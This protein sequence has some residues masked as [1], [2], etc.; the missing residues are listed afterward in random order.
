MFDSGNAKKCG[1][2]SGL[3]I[4]TLD[5]QAGKRDR[6]HATQSI[7]H[8]DSSTVRQ[9]EK[10]YKILEKHIVY[11][12]FTSIWRWWSVH[13]LF[14]ILKLRTTQYCIQTKRVTSRWDLLLEFHRS[15]TLQKPVR[16]IVKY[17][18]RAKHL[19]CIFNVCANSTWFSSS[20]SALR[21]GL[22][23]DIEHIIAV[24][25]TGKSLLLSMDAHKTVRSD[26]YKKMPSM[27]K[28]EIYRSH[29]HTLSNNRWS[30][31]GGCFEKV[32]TLE[33]PR[34]ICSLTS[35]SRFCASLL[36]FFLSLESPFYSGKTCYG[37]RCRTTWM[38]L[39]SNRLSRSRSL[40]R[41]SRRELRVSFS[42]RSTISALW[43]AP[44][45]TLRL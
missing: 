35:R 12:L 33:W 28:N 39:T 9:F 31:D 4:H 24:E 27:N 29:M 20:A 8:A 34:A 38:W 17:K 23:I 5:G 22:V 1:V 15:Q 3:F 6:M 10:R 19:L 13:S 36:D 16:Q 42:F 21:D 40:F 41:S 30:Y 32:W 14:K 43:I 11:R 25:A 26:A 44:A 18:W 37:R 45:V 7:S 2:I